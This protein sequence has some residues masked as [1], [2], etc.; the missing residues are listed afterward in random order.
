MN[1]KGGYFLYLQFIILRSIY[2]GLLPVKHTRFGIKRVP[3]IWQWGWALA[4]AI[5]RYYT[6]TVSNQYTGLHQ[7]TGRR[8]GAS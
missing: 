4:A 2:V 6:D 3:G 7:Y 8:V 1:N 5:S